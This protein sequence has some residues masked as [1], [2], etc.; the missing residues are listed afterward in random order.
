VRFR[1]L[2]PLEVWTGQDWS[3]IGAPK[4][5]ALL[6]ALLLNQG[7]V[8]STDRLIAEL[9]GDAAPDRAPNLVSVYVLRL[10][11]V[12]GDPDGRILTT[13][14][15]GYQLLLHPG[16]L[17]AE[18]FQTLHGQ[19]RRALAAGDC[20]AAAEVL[21]AALALWRGRALADVPPSP[22]VTAEADRLE[23]SR[24]AA[25]E[26]RIEADLGCDLHA[27]LVPE[28]R[29]LL[30]DQPLR[31]GLW[32][33]LIRALDGAGRHA[34]ALA[35]YGQA[36]EVISDELGVDP[37]SELQR[38]Y[39][40]MLT[41][42]AVTPQDPA[43]PRAAGASGPQ[44]KPVTGPRGAAAAGPRAEPVTGPRGA[45]A[46]GPRAK[47]VT[48]PRGAAAA[49][50]RAE[51]VTGPRAARAAGPQAEPVTSLP[52]TGPPAAPV[53]IP[54]TAAPSAAA[55]EM[56]PRRAGA[57][58]SA[59]RVPAQ[60]PADVSDFT[61]RDEDLER[62]C[63]LVSGSHGR[64]NP[65][66]TVAVVAGAPGLGKTAL[67]I[68]AAHALRPQFPNGQLYARLLGGSERPVA[69]DEVLARFLR[70]LGVDG[71]RVPVD[72]E[73]RAAMYRTRLA[74]RQTLIVLD[75]AR[76]AAQVRPLLPGTGSCAVIVTSRQRLSDLAGSRLIDLDVLGGGE[77][78]ELFTRIIG[79]DRSGAEPD[80]VHDVLTICAGLPLAIRIAGARLTARRGWSVRTLAGRLADQ[81]RRIDELTAGDLAVRACFQVSFDTLPRRL[82]GDGI[83]PAHVFRMLGVWQG[84]SIGLPAAA[85][86]LGRPE[87][88]VADALE[89]L[90]DAHLLES[91]A[92][93]RYRLH[94]L[95][96][97]YALERAQADE[98]RQDMEDAIR[99]VLDWYLRTADA[100]ASVVAP[101]LNRV[102]LGPMLPGCE[103]LAFATAEQALAWCEH[104]RANLVTATRQAA[105]HG[106][107]DIAWKLPVAMRVCLDRLG[108][109]TEW[110]TTH[111]T[112]LASARELGDRRGE[113][114]V[115]TNLGMVLGQQR[116]NDAIGYFEQALVIYRETGDRQD[117]AQAANNLAFTYLILGRH[118][119]AVE[120]LLDALRLQ[121]EAGRRYGEGVALCNLG[122]AYVELGRY[123]EAIACSQEALA[124]VR[125]VGSV[126]DEGYALYNLGRAHLDLGR[127]GE[128]ADLF[129]QAL[130]IHRAAGDRYGEA[131]DLQRIGATHS[132]EGRVAQARESWIR[133]RTMFESLGEDERATEV[134]TQLA[135][136][137][138]V[139]NVPAVTEVTKNEY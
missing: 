9:W 62:L 100:A 124:I 103:P 137:S 74:E 41:A 53:T 16:E 44:A 68:H 15:P 37:G 110:L 111:R 59:R 85:A 73:E 132:R 10:R 117:E 82:V 45:G 63:G 24:L 4:W 40:K 101:Y 138:P 114:W 135:G 52:V 26:L 106:L 12:L 25:L 122:E 79:P 67:A 71:A 11:R 120:A 119:E 127:L 13:R 78:A 38:L 130:P 34:E 107:H 27:E 64:D 113:A 136:L 22:L 18:Y 65:A 139:V 60:L 17:D 76:D 92:P 14:A 6:A 99:R 112:G 134:G 7:Q 49:G 126:R 75:D 104:E 81:R 23:E 118:E 29:R 19:G 95:L 8:V 88:P 69:A 50:P 94:D 108:Y 128:A 48:G 2:G 109:R 43:G 21:A 116:V 125:E 46:A 57:G 83:D 20:R 123:E 47:P 28:L 30:R 36:R 54:A 70:D 91:P 31:E 86:L 84:P 58:S 97:A 133:A 93:D 98:Q 129:G 66:V 61:G 42:D 105:S 55:P 72:A 90:V 32:A 102:A 96:R 1:I 121:R 33:L 80:A 89:V 87:D 77:A 35:A 5:R 131:Q 115:L 39:R 56:R 3:G 51:P